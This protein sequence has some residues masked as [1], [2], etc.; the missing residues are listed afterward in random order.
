MRSFSFVP[1]FEMGYFF[2]SGN[3]LLDDNS[4]IYTVGLVENTLNYN[5]NFGKHN[6]DVVLGQTFQKNT[7]II[8]TAYSED[9]PKPYYPVLSNGVNQTVGGR[10]ES[11]PLLILED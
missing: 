3:S 8:R 5:T 11:S 1:Q 6:F 4:T 10:I 7:T 2:G 9:L